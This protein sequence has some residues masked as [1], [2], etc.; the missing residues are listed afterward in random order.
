MHASGVHAHWHGACHRK[1]SRGLFSLKGSEQL[2]DT[3]CCARC[4]S[5]ARGLQSS[6]NPTGIGETHLFIKPN[7][8]LLGH[9]AGAL[10]S[11]AAQPHNV[12]VNL[13]NG[14]STATQQLQV[15]QLACKSD[16]QAHGTATSLRSCH[17]M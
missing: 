6:G 8:S 2:T 14:K 5:S 9:P 17:D 10:D 7:L 1:G 12:Q 3:R 13:G 4:A 15:M 11:P 16:T